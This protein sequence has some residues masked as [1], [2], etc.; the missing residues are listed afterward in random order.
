M[1]RPAPL[2]GVLV[3]DFSR[4]LAGPLT[5][6]MPADLGAEVIKVERPGTGDE[7]RAWGP[8]WT[9]ETSTYFEC[10]NRSKKS[11]TLDLQDPHDLA[12]AREL[13][14]RSGHAGGE[15]QTRDHG[16]VRTRR[17]GAPTRAWCTARSRTSAPAREP[18]CP[19]TTSSCRPSGV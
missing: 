11:I 17:C 18:T 10:A 12:A 5:T 4:I 1:T 6:V 3:A 8:P 13:A 16:P 14:A 9:E 7:T 15:L 2:D 19:G